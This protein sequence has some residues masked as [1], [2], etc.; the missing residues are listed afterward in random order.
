M[1]HQNLP[2]DLLRTFVTVADHKSFT[3]AGDILGRTQPAISLQ[4]RRLEELVGCELISTRGRANLL[5]PVGEEFVRFARQ[6]LCLNDEIVARLQNR[7]AEG[8]L[9]V[10]L[11]VDYAVAFFQELLTKFLRE[12]AEVELEIVCELSK[13]LLGRLDAGELDVVVAMYDGV[14]PSN[15]AF[16]WAERPIWVAAK[17][18]AFDRQTPVRLLAH[19]E[20]CE[21]R[22]RMIRALDEVGRPWRVVYSSPGISGLQDAVLSGLGI[23]ALT[24]RTLRPGMKVLG[25]E[26][27]LPP[28]DDVHVGLHY[29][30][31][32]QSTAGKRLA[33]VIMAAL[34]ESGQTELIRIDRPFHHTAA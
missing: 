32:V 24:K 20:G 11:P 17:A 10:G 30:H 2:T 13:R 31:S 12:N 21:Y 14:A 16:A 4:I 19:N 6:M 9:R 7:R 25:E 22:S 26:T 8:S 5:T 1:A 27:G 23:S 3:K 29:K 33:G 18:L 15:L 34:Q 28:L